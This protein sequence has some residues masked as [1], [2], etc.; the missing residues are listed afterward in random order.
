MVESNIVE[1]V[2]LLHPHSQSLLGE[3]EDMFPNDLPSRLPPLTG[4]EHQ[5]SL[6]LGAPL[7]NKLAYK[8]NPNESNELQ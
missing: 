7:A 1:V 4:I 8:C 5:I 2:K 3:F 6:L